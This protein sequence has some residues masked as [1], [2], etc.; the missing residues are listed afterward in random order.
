MVLQSAIRGLVE[1]LEQRVMLSLT[2]ATYLGPIDAPGTQWTYKVT[3]ADGQS[4]TF[5]RRVVGPAT[6]NGIACTE[7]DQ[8]FNLQ[9][10]FF[11]GFDSA[12]NWNQYGS[13]LVT[14]S[15]DTNTEIYTPAQQTPAHGTAGVVYSQ[16]TITDGTTTDS[17]GKVT[18]TSKFSTTRHDTIPSETTTSIM[19]PL[20]TYDVIDLHETGTDTQINPDGSMGEPTTT[21]PSDSYFAD[22]VGLVKLT[23]SAVTYELIA[24]S[25][26]NDHLKFTVQPPPKTDAGKP[27]T[28][29]IEVT[30][31]DS[32]DNPDLTATDTVT[33]SLNDFVNSGT[34]SLSGTVTQPLVAGV[35]TFTG[36]SV[37]KDGNYQFN[38]TD[39]N[40]DPAAQSNKFRIGSTALPLVLNS[41]APGGAKGVKSGDVI[42]YSIVVSPKKALQGQ[43]M[44]VTFPTGFTVSG[45]LVGGTVSGNTITWTNNS[46]AFNFYLKVPDA[47][48]LNGIKTVVVS[49]EDNVTYAD[50]TD[51]QATTSNSVKLATSYEIDGTVRD[52]IFKF[53]HLAKVVTS[54]ALAGVTVNMIDSS[55]AIVDTV[56]TKSNGKFAV[57]AKSAGDY[58]LQFVD[59]AFIYTADATANVFSKQ[60]FYVTQS[61][62]FEPSNT[63]PIDLGNLIMPKTFLDNSAPILYR[64]NHYKTS[65]FQ[66]LPSF[67]IDLFQFDTSGAEGVLSGLMGTAAAPGKFLNVDAL[68]LGGEKDPWVAAIRMMAGLYVVDQRF[69]DALKLVDLS[70]KALSVTLSVAFVKKLSGLTRAGNMKFPGQKT[71]GSKAPFQQDLT[72]QALSQG[73][74]IAAFTTLGAVISPALDKVFSTFG[75]KS[76]YKAPVIAGI[77]ST[78]RFGYDLLTGQKLLDDLGFEAVFNL[79]RLAFD[80]TMLGSLTGVKVRTDIA[81]PY[82]VILGVPAVAGELL[83]DLPPNMQKVID[84]LVDNRASYDTGIDTELDLSLLSDYADNGHQSF[85]QFRQPLSVLNTVSSVLRG[86]DGVLFQYGKANTAI[87][88]NFVQKQLQAAL[89]KGEVALKAVVGLGSKALSAAVL[90]PAMASGAGGLLYQLLSCQYVASVARTGSA[91]TATAS[92]SAVS[93]SIASLSSPASTSA[94]ATTSAAVAVNAATTSA[95]AAASAPTALS[96]CLADLTQLSKLVKSGD[97]DGIAAFYPQL[98]SDNK[99]LFNSDLMIL[100]DQAKALVPQLSK[101]QIGIAGT[102]DQALNFAVGSVV[103]ASEQLDTWGFNPAEG[104]RKAVLTQISTTISAIKSAA[105][106]ATAVR[107]IVAGF[108]IPATLA[109]D[110]SETPLSAASGSTITVSVTVTNIGNQPSGPGT[111]RFSNSNGSLVLASPAQLNIAPLG[112]GASAIYTWQVQ[113]NAPANPNFGVVYQI[114]TDTGGPNTSISNDL[115]V[116]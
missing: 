110:A 68:K 92:A 62:T 76:S 111:I 81:T 40:G 59:S 102:F 77:F 43:A 26:T 65:G 7:M 105:S 5:I 18:A 3:L 17:T 24:F 115:A 29:A 38:A 42:R 70:G 52:A 112:A 72:D 11:Y 33:L 90:V 98:L 96:V 55:G 56:V 10:K 89:S 51:D 27:L 109:L 86:G 32:T 63:T 84:D 23:S 80:V 44:V 94:P 114:Q 97:K 21:T 75:I 50:G 9:E 46:H 41:K 103:F 91:S 8:G 49:V 16:T 20:G 69:N 2:A 15:G 66:N 47:K 30:A 100:D 107:K 79:I 99:A 93:T 35:A 22:G 113:V 104:D 34:G 74:R 48:T 116:T 36:L 13:S 108:E 82:K 67:D 12:G 14:G 45:K 37:S 85:A 4:G 25:S 60:Q 53:P 31:Y 73:S 95:A 71:W 106:K 64:L 57:T 87:N 78:L 6:F 39:S 19:V 28:P 88:G 101:A 1:A 54:A 83:G 58:T 61:V